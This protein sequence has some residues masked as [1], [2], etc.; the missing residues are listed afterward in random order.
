MIQDFHITEAIS[1]AQKIKWIE[2]TLS[3]KNELKHS[4]AKRNAIISNSAHIRSEP[5][6]I[7]DEILFKTLKQ[8][9]E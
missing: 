8:A 6:A 3:Y 5:K 1:T 7:P 9:E 2:E 4:F